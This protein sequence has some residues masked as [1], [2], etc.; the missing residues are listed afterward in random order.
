MNPR[1]HERATEIFLSVCDL[2]PAQRAAAIDSS[3]GGDVELREEVLSLLA[4]DESPPG[5]GEAGG[6]GDGSSDF[7]G[8]D[9]EGLI[10]EAHPG[11]I[12]RYR[13]LQ[14]LGEGGMAT[15]FLAE[16][17]G[18]DGRR[19]ALKMINAWRRYIPLTLIR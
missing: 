9:R 4:H 2:P 10:P 12:G 18:G 16:L 5:P 3:C 7:V 15:V 17:S 1:L 13:I 19:V 6:E 14:S 8:G 11:L